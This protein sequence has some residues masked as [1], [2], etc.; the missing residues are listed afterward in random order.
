MDREQLSR[1]L[2]RYSHEELEQLLMEMHETLTEPGT[3]KSE[4]VRQLLEVPRRQMHD[5]P[6]VQL[7]EFL[8]AEVSNKTDLNSLCRTHKNI[9]KICKDPVF[10]RDWQMKYVGFPLTGHT[11]DVNSVAWSPDGSLIASGGRD[12]KIRLWNAKTLE[13]LNKK[14]WD[15]FEGK[16]V[17]PFLVHDD[18]I[19]AIVWKSDGTQFASGSADGTIRIWDPSTGGL[20]QMKRIGPGILDIAW[21]PDGSTLASI[22]FRHQMFL[23]NLIT[24]TQRRVDFP[25]SRMTSVVWNP[26][27]TKLAIA[28]GSD[29]QLLD[30]NTLQHIHSLQDTRQDTLNNTFLDIAWHPDG[31]KLA[32]ASRDRTIRLW[33]SNTGQQIN[34][35]VGLIS[36]AFTVSWNPDG[37]RLASSGGNTILIWDHNTNRMVREITTDLER[38]YTVS[39][40][41]KGTILAVAGATGIRLWSV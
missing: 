28:T 27:G 31:F 29:I 36:P 21:S 9:A 39:W 24:G 23:W 37:S 6:E 8:M 4:L 33:D 7:R 13:L 18:Q 2:S 41:P 22:D 10:R 3:K 32:S 20:I 35:L 17:K 5:L 19:N 38:I 16:N 14:L 1:Q 34:K 12:R 25:T 40:N 26:D 11:D 30:A 15:T